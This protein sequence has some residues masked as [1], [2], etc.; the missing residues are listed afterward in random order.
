MELLIVMGIGTGAI[1]VLTQGMR[2]ARQSDLR[3]DTAH[4]AAALRTAYNLA[5]QTGKHHRVLFDLST[6]C[7]DDGEEAGEG[8]CQTF[9]VQACE[10]DFKMRRE[11]R[12]ELGDPGEA[13]PP[14]QT[15]DVVAEIQEAESP[16]EAAAQARALAGRRLGTAV[17]GPVV[18]P[19]GR[20]DKRGKLRHLQTWNE[21]RIQRVYVQHLEEPARTG[22]VTIN[23]FPQGY[24]EK[25]VVV[26][27][28]D[29]DHQFT[30]LVHGLTGRVEYKDGD[31]R[32]PDEHMLRDG[33]GERVEERAP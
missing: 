11:R 19:D 25:A 2:Q 16:A 1:V 12:E 24:A 15:T 14:P 9:Q 21:I 26:L 27:G 6:A 5:A 22:P 18:K 31:W 20:P 10:G 13:P 30:L 32:R 33:A 4:V 3:Q 28:D 7:E 17:C 8:K 23:F 29:D